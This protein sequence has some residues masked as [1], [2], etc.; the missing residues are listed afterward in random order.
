MD[1]GVREAGSDGSFLPVFWS[2]SLLKTIFMRV[3]PIRQPTE[4]NLALKIKTMRD[5]SSPRA[6]R[7]DMG[8]FFNKLLRIADN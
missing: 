1:N 5:S 6:P 4:R 8:E 2:K 7:N 3:I